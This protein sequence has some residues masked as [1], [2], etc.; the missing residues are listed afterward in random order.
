MSKK[1]KKRFFVH[2][3]CRLRLGALHVS[4]E[5]QS[6]QDTRKAVKNKVLIVP[7][8]LLFPLLIAV[9]LRKLNVNKINKKEARRKRD[10]FQHFRR[11]FVVKCTKNLLFL[12]INTTAA[13]LMTALVVKKNG[14]NSDGNDPGTRVPGR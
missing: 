9:F 14:E 6:G 11:I 13:K 5:I 10:F 8:L 7:A 2:Y 12:R 4:C 1:I 3:F